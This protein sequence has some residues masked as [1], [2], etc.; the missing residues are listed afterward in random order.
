MTAKRRNPK[1]APSPA[2]KFT[3]E[4]ASFL[5]A[6]VEDGLEIQPRFRP[7]PLLAKTGRG[8]MASGGISEIAAA[9]DKARG[10]RK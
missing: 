6:A 2:Q 9:K 10:S 3:A 8:F 5:A 7:E 4:E 1:P